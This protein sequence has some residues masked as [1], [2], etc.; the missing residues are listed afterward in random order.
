[1]T[2]G[3]ARIVATP[4]T[5]SF[6]SDNASG[7]HPSVMAA[8]GEA[9]A[10]HALAYGADDWTAAATAALRD[11]LGADAEV[12]FTWGGTGANVVGLGCML[13]PWQAVLCTDVA[14]IVVDECGAPERFTGSKLI[15]LPAADGKLVPDQIVAQLHALGDEHHVQPR[16]VSL[17]E[18]TEMGTLYTPDELVELTAT[19]HA[20][21]LLVHVDGAR[22]SNAVAALGCTL[23][24]LVVDTGIDVFTFGGTKN[25]M[26]YGEAVVFLRP[27]LAEPARFV[28]KQ[29][30]QLPSKLRFVAAQFRALLADGLWLS[31]A[32]HANEMADRLARGARSVPGVEVVVPS[33]AN[34]VFATVPAAVVEPLREWSPHWVWDHDQHMVRWMCSFDTPAEDVDRFLAGLAEAC[35]SALLR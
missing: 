2:A 13:R 26:M 12:V 27:E 19:A 11:L 6:A 23:G 34:A 5:T 1:M 30:A 33:E 29:A 14:H 28:R 7:V 31:N 25:G 24:E 10:G 35:G 16:V 17:T 18:P 4:P 8:L 21:G 9:N 15:D 20:H 22:I 3:V 32:S